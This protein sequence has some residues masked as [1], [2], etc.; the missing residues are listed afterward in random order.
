MSYRNDSAYEASFMGLA[1]GTVYYDPYNTPEQNN[2]N[3]KKS[4][5]DSRNIVSFI[6]RTHI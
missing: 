2:A 6:Y 5:N 4:L 3:L 1:D